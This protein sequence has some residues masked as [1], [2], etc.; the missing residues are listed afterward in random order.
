MSNR[1]VVSRLRRENLISNIKSRSNTKSRPKGSLKIKPRTKRRFSPNTSNLRKT[2]LQNRTRKYAPKRTVFNNST[3]MTKGMK[4]ILYSHRY[5]HDDFIRE[6]RETAERERKEALESIDDPAYL[7]ILGSVYEVEPPERM[8]ERRRKRVEENFP[9]P[10]LQTHNE[11]KRYGPKGQKRAIQNII[12]GRNK[13]VNCGKAMT[14]RNDLVI[15]PFTGTK[16]HRVHPEQRHYDG[17]GLPN[18]INNIYYRGKVPAM[19]KMSHKKYNARPNVVTAPYS[20]F[21]GKMPQR[22]VGRFTV[23]VPDT[24]NEPK[25]VG[26][27]TVSVPNYSNKP[28]KVGRFTVTSRQ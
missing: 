5:N 7:H 1:S 4:K 2:L 26:R 19:V 27:F 13:C 8:K 23:S 16:T 28:K 22:K 10:V 18:N 14:S 17:I 6:Q 12:K 11:A 15:D 3:P 9:E 24:N 21:K 20:K 25:K